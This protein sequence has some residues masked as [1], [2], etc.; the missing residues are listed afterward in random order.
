MKNKLK[1]ISK[2]LSLV[3]RHQP[4]KIDLKLDAQGWA[5]TQELIN[6][7]PNLTLELLKEVVSTNA[8]KRFAFNEDGSKIRASQGHS[9]SVELG[10]SPSQPPT[11]LY[12]GTATQ[13]LD[14]IAIKGLLKMNRQHVHLSENIETATQV[15]QRH[16]KLVLLEVAA[17][18]MQEAGFLFYLSANGVWLTDEV[19]VEYLIF[20][21]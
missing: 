16:G 8:K 20:P 12:H 11:I 5:E 2:F 4:Q 17:E 18:A 14:A 19:P 7:M 1:N 13:H 3:L 21:G 6:K 9:L 15:G 10:Y